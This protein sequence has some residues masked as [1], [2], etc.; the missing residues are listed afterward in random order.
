MILDCSWSRSLASASGKFIEQLAPDQHAAD[1]AGAG[2][3]LVEL[4]VAQ[5]AAGRIVVDIAIAAEQ[6]DRVERALRRLFGSVEDGAGGVLSGGLATVAGLRY[7]IDI[8]TRRIHRRI[9]V[10]NLALHE[11]ER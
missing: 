10:G 6:L 11:L 2:A 3:D 7:R 4:G 8:G 1:F 5:Q 9:H